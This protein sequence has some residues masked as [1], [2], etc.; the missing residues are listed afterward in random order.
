MGVCASTSQ[1]SLMHLKCRRLAARSA[2]CAL[3]HLGGVAA[4]CLALGDSR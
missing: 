3:S 2:G 4:R 1:S